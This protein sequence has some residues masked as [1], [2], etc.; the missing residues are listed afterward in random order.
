MEKN[1][2]HETLWTS[3]SKSW[4]N[5]ARLQL[6]EGQKLTAEHP[7][8]AACRQLPAAE[9][10]CPAAPAAAAPSARGWSGLCMPAGCSQ[11]RAPRCWAAAAAAKASGCCTSCTRGACSAWKAD[12]E[13]LHRGVTSIS[14]TVKEVTLQTWHWSMLIF[15]QNITG[16]KRESYSHLQL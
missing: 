1:T 9:P 2:K 6:W 4:L 16:E 10:R 3:R 8:G 12:R 14:V 15:Y 13:E 5:P 7:P 11:E